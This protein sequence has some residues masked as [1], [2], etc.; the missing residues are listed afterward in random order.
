MGSEGDYTFKFYTGNFP[1]AGGH[2]PEI[3]LFG[4]MEGE[5]TKTNH[6]GWAGFLWK[7]NDGSEEE[8]SVNTNHKIAQA[9]M[10]S[11]G[12]DAIC[13]TAVR[14]NQRGG[15]QGVLLGNIAS[16]CGK[17]WSWAGEPVYTNEGRKY[18]KCI[19]LEDTRGSRQDTIG[20]LVWE[21][22]AGSKNGIEYFNTHADEICDPPAFWTDPQSFH[23]MNRNKRM[24]EDL[25]AIKKF[26]ETIDS[27]VQSPCIAKKTCT[28]EGYKGPH[29]HDAELNEICNVNDFTLHT[30]VT[31]DT[32]V[33]FLTD[34]GIEIKK[35][36]LRRSVNTSSFGS[37]LVPQ[38][39]DTFKV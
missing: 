13:L 4:S 1:G 23:F 10:I 27:Y 29:I 15:G 11:G 32:M 14:Y 33:Q 18:V 36:I 5:H 31:R 24:I 28:E 16:T 17:I 9:L 2:C 25:G 34:S 39:Y 3:R 8:I 20:R 26:Y 12:S 22:Q 19:W 30:N 7:I 35:K 21:M 38:E 37:K 6:V